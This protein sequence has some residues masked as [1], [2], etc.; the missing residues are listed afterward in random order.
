MVKRQRP[1]SEKDLGLAM[2][3]MDEFHKDALYN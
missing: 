3:E 2:A 1:S